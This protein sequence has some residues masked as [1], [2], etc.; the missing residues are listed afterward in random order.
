MTYQE[1]R[2]ALAEFPGNGWSLYGLSRTLQEQGE[3]A[4][5]EQALQQYRF[6]WARA[7]AAPLTTSCKCIDKF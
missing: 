2:E 6:S 1:L 4:E 7:D 3:T 5:A